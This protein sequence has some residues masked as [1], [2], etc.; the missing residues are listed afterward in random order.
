MSEKKTFE[1]S[2]S[3]LEGVV[4]QLEVGDVPLE[5]SMKAFEKGIGLIREC[6]AKLEDA[7]GKIEKLIKESGG[8]LKTAPFETKE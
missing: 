3:E 8:D 5:E 4:R 1:K 6:E 2:M 7:K